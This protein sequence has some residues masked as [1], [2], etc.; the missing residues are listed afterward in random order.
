MLVQVEAGC[1]PFHKAHGIEAKDTGILINE[2]QDDADEFFAERLEKSK[3]TWSSLKVHQT[4]F[5]LRRCNRLQQG[6][7]T[8]ADY[9][10]DVK[11][12]IDRQNS[13]RQV[14]RH[15]QTVEPRAGSGPMVQDDIG[16]DFQ[17]G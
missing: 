11:I 3:S 13:C 4:R 8:R 5:L 2:I 1:P 12:L 14:S 6:M 10:R 16:H 9:I 15:R 7:F 17:R